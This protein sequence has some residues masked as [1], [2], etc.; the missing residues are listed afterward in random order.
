MNYFLFE[1]NNDLIS[2]YL[3]AIFF[4]RPVKAREVN[5]VPWSVLNISGTPWL[6]M[7]SSR[8]ATQKSASRVFDNRQESTRRECQ[9][10]TAA[11]YRNHG[12]WGCR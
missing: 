4:S 9:S 3:D 5:G 1:M 12:A 6:S 11:R 10:I 2:G 8:A 7:A